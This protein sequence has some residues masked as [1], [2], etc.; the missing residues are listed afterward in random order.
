MTVPASPK[1]SRLGQALERDLSTPLHVLLIFVFASLLPAESLQGLSQ[2]GYCREFGRG[3][4]PR[5]LPPAVGSPQRHC[6]L[7]TLLSCLSLRLFLRGGSNPPTAAPLGTQD[8]VGSEDAWK[9]FCQFVSA[10]G[11]PAP[12]HDPD[13]LPR[14]RDEDAEEIFLGGGEDGIDDPRLR[15]LFDALPDFGKPRQPLEMIDAGDIIEVRPRRSS[16]HG[17]GTSKQAGSVGAGSACIENETVLA[18]ADTVAPKKMT[19]EHVTEAFSAGGSRGTWEDE[20][21]PYHAQVLD[22]PMLLASEHPADVCA[23][24]YKFFPYLQRFDRVL[25][26][27][28]HPSHDAAALKQT[29]ALRQ[30]V[31]LFYPQLESEVIEMFEA[32]AS[33]N[34]WLVAV[35]QAPD[36]SALLQ[37]IPRSWARVVSPPVPRQDVPTSADGCGSNASL[38]P[39]VEVN[40]GASWPGPG[41]GGGRIASP[42]AQNKGNA[43]VVLPQMAKEMVWVR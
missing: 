39:R 27:G 30:F 14:I 38:E 26:A 15:Y 11:L 43:C 33:S 34:A 4:A 1:V 35:A 23:H 5:P 13:S 9:S 18:S 6:F 22:L 40:R 31:E 21:R 36:G 10:Q 28:P 37:K 2:F 3:A 25:S 24:H 20:T 8:A 32:T 41:G 42:T 29:Y 16:S 7:P 17:S 19:D 12:P